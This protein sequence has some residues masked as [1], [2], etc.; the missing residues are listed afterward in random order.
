MIFMECAFNYR[1][2]YYYAIVL[3]M[4]TQLVDLG[5]IGVHVLIRIPDQYLLC[6]KTKVIHHNNYCTC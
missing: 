5:C 6:N 3:F 1:T 4:L 2:L